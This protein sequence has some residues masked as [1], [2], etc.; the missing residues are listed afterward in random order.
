M[1]MDVS[2]TQIGEQTFT[3]ACLRDIS[4]RQAHIEALGHQALHDPLTG[5]PNR[6]L[7]ADRVDRASRPRSGRT[8][9]AGC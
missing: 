9:R 5:L 4:E 8:S 6:T 1:E 7:F 2:H 3:I